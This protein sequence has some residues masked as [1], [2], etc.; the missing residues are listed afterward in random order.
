MFPQ[1]PMIPVV[2]CRSNMKYSAIRMCTEQSY[3]VYSEIFFH[4]FSL[5]RRT[6]EECIEKQ[7]DCN[8]AEN[9]DKIKWER[10]IRLKWDLMPN[11]LI[12][13]EQFRRISFSELPETMRKNALAKQLFEQYHTEDESYIAV[14]IELL[15]K[16]NLPADFSPNHPDYQI[17]SRRNKYKMILQ[18]LIEKGV[19]NG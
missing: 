18:E 2:M 13:G 17:P 5:V 6:L 8:V 19:S 10:W 16:Y 7:D 4:H 14:P 11:P 15:A 9:V 1:C 12:D 3:S